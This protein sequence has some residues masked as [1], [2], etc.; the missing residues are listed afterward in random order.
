[1]NK[2]IPDQGISETIFY[3]DLVI[4]STELL[5]TLILVIYSKRL[6]NVIQKLDI[7]WISCGSLYTWL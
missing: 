1:M 5:E 7:T 4:Y 3:G 6:S 2:M